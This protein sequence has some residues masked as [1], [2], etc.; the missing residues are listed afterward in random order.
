[1]ESLAIGKTS[2]LQFASLRR[3]DHLRKNTILVG[4]M[5]A[6]ESSKLRQKTDHHPYYM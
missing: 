3:S 2:A 6:T 1:M 5:G 4:E